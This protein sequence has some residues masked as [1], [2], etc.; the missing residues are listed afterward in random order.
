VPTV[1]IDGKK[2]KKYSLNFIS[3]FL[4]QNLKDVNASFTAND[5]SRDRKL[6]LP[7][8]LALIINMVR[9]GKRFGYQEVINRFF[10][11]TGLAHEKG[12]TPPDKSA[13]FRAS[14]DYSSK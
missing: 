3:S 14:P 13:L 6:P 7:I 8:T 12:I 2:T 4:P 10:S 1:E 5:F 11:D 9:P